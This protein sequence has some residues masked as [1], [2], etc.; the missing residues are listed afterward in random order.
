[1][2]LCAD[3]IMGIDCEDLLKEYLDIISVVSMFHRN[4]DCFT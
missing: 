2:S 4:I 1:M 3:F